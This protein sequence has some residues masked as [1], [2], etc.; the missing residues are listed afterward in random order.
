MKS[1]PVVVAD[2][3]PPMF[4]QDR[5]RFLPEDFASERVFWRGRPVRVDSY[6]DAATNV[7]TFR[8]SAEGKR[9]I[10]FAF[11]EELLADWRSPREELRDLI[12][13]TWTPPAP[14]TNRIGKRDQIRAVRAYMAPRAF[15]SRFR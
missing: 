8:A 7:V 11:G 14:W 2:L 12:D 15:R 1:N 4:E 10:E 13:V 3:R 9:P 5:S 6:R